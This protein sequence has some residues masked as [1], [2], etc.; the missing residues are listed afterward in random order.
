M[1]PIL[2]EEVKIRIQNG[3]NSHKEIIEKAVA[4]Q[5]C[6]RR[7]G[8]YP[9]WGG[10]GQAGDC[11]WRPG[12]KRT[13]L[14]WWWP[15]LNFPH[16]HRLLLL[17]HHHSHSCRNRFHSLTIII[18]NRACLPWWYGFQEWPKSHRAKIGWE[19]RVSNRG[20]RSSPDPFRTWA[21]HLAWG[22]RHKKH[23]AVFDKSFPFLKLVPINWSLRWSVFWSWWPSWALSLPHGGGNPRPQ[24]VSFK[25]KMTVERMIFGDQIA[26]RLK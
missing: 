1:R 22:R 17:L 2:K 3:D 15:F 25:V 13:S 18:I 7:P 24:G 11:A 12:E 26:R 10:R 23:K 4:E 19:T 9:G 6:W 8:F 14:P 20:G 21:A 5:A 16:R